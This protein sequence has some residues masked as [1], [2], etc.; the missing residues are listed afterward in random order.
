MISV[1]FVALRFFC[2]MVFDARSIE[3]AKMIAP[4]LVLDGLVSGPR[5]E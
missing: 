4:F 5:S 1:R 3:L 2:R